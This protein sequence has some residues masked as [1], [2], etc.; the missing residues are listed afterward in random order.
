M[1]KISTLLLIVAML[2]IA[3]SC[4]SCGAQ[5]QESDKFIDTVIFSV[6]G[7]DSPFAQQMT[8]FEPFMNAKSYVEKLSDTLNEITTTLESVNFVGIIIAIVTQGAAWLA[9]IIVYLAAII[10]LALFDLCWMFALLIIFAVF[11]LI[12]LLG[13]FFGFFYALFV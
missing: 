4:T 8:N 13:G 12:Y 7:E 9:A 6:I 1:R 10:Y 11:T 3:F 2:I 5:E